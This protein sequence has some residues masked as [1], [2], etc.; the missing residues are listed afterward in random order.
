ML[1]DCTRC[2]GTDGLGRSTVTPILAGQNENYLHASLR[3]YADGRR[4]SGVM[5]LPAAT[6]DPDTL[7]RLASHFSSLPRPTVN[8]DPVDP[9]V[10]S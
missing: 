6:A 4:P 7:G 5:R 10:L 9:A 3:A 8:A 1:A 2:H